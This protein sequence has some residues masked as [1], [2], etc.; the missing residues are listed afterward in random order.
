MR[1]VVLG[2][3]GGIGRDLVGAACA[4][5][6][7]GIITGAQ[8]LQLGEVDL[9]IAGGVSE[10]SPSQPKGYTFSNSRM[11]LRGALARHTP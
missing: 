5:G 11:A 4:A 1:L 10:S 3:C 8:M 2:G 9:A 6:N 7:L